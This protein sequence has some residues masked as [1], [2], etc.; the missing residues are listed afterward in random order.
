MKTSSCQ[1]DKIFQFL[2]RSKFQETGLSNKVLFSSS[3][4]S[5]NSSR[6]LKLWPSSATIWK[7]GDL[8]RRKKT[9]GQKTNHVITHNPII[10]WFLLTQ[11]EYKS[12]FL[13]PLTTIFL[14]DF[15]SPSLRKRNPIEL[16]QSS[17]V[18]SLSA[19]KISCINYLQNL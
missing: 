5:F 6:S 4:H 17:A 3:E 11:N 7:T 16:N 15:F 19:Q 8:F 13:I 2:Y 9:A 1:K 12:K 10:L 18:Q 14:Y